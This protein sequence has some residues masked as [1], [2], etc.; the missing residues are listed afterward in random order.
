MLTKPRQLCWTHIS[1]EI[2]DLSFTLD[3]VSRLLLY[4]SL[5]RVK[6]I[7]CSR[8]NTWIQYFCILRR[9]HLLHYFQGNFIS[10]YLKNNIFV[11][12]YDI[13]SFRYIKRRDS[14]RIEPL[15]TNDSGV[16]SCMT[17]RDQ[18]HKWS[19][20]TLIVTGILSLI[21]LSFLQKV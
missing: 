9:T 6:L 14:L 11:N 12:D 5:Y 3:S 17:T 19:N 1:C 2:F 15:H 13:F 20:V 10:A 21:A 18:C 16:Y 8:Q 4:T 7:S